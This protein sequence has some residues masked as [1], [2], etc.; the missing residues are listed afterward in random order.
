MGKR[1]GGRGI[2]SGVLVGAV[3]QLGGLA[4]STLPLEGNISFKEDQSSQRVVEKEAAYIA[5][6]L[7]T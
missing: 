3:P 2:L 6:S 7:R 1:V 4:L 5:V